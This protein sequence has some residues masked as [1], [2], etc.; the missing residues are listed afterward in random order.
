MQERKH[1]FWIIWIMVTLLFGLLSSAPGATVTWVGGVSSNWADTNNWN[2]TTALPGTNDNAYFPT[3]SVG[4]VIP[5]NTTQSVGSLD[6]RG[7][8]D[9]AG[10][11]KMIIQ[12][13]AALHSITNATRYIFTG[14]G[15]RG[16]IEI[17]SNAMLTS[18][19]C[20]FHIVSGNGGQPM[21]GT[22]D[23]IGGT[24]SAG[25]STLSIGNANMNRSQ[26]GYTGMIHVTAG[27]LLSAGTIYV[28][29][30]GWGTTDVGRAVLTISNEGSRVQ[31]S[32]SFQISPAGY[33]SGGNGRGTVI[34]YGGTLSTPT[35]YN[36]Y[37]LNN[38]NGTTNV[39]EFIIRG[40]QLLV[41]GSLYNHVTA[42]RTNTE[43]GIITI[44]SGATNLQVG[45][46]YYQ[47]TNGTLVAEIT[48]T[49]HP[50]LQVSGIA[51]LAGTLR[52]SSNS[53]EQLGQWDIISGTL[54]GSFNTFDVSAAAHPANWSLS[55][56]ANKVILS[57]T[58]RGTLVKCH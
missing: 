32:G 31:C 4:C 11:R 1:T 40:G 41:S 54:S 58:P 20:N 46:N 30:G 33:N 45:G 9:A 34:M 23:I 14:T 27:G 15:D 13:G 44:A 43:C 48:A 47:R 12:P 10:L 16:A 42:D 7:F 2:P 49:S 17:Q 29:S 52:V 51:Y 26:S 37:A 18:S 21:Q 28:G 36:A 6:F 24:L 22:I 8:A 39:A 25:G 19:N 53:V 5:S 38:T 56:T 50:P 55:Y 3:T 35:F 57:Y